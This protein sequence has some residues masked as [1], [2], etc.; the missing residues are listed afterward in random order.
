MQNMIFANIWLGDTLPYRPFEQRGPGAKT[1]I[2]SAKS[3]LHWIGNISVVH[4]Q[5]RVN[6]LEID[7]LNTKPEKVHH[8]VSGAMAIMNAISRICKN[9]PTL[10]SRSGSREGK[11]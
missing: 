2:S 8:T 7:V 3:L 11:T 4:K 10:S 5:R 1:P 9:S 6:V